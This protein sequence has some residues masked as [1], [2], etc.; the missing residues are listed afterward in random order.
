MEP[1]FKT[2]DNGMR[3]VFK[4]VEKDRP[5]TLFVCVKAGSVN[6]TD[7]N[8]GISHFIEHLNFKGT[9]K[10]SAKQIST[11]FEEIGANANAF[12]SKFTTCYFATTLAEQ[13][14][15]CFDILSDIIF[16]SKYSDED[17]DRE[18]K[19]VFE[20][21]DM[22][23]DDPESVSYEEFTKNFYE[24]TTLQ[25][26]VLGTK[27]SLKG[28]TRQDIVDYVKSNYIAPNIIVSVVGH[29]EEDFIEKLTCKYFSNRFKD[30]CALPQIDK[31]KQVSPIKKF[32][33]IEKDVAQTHITFGFPCPNTY[34]KNRMAYILA[35][36]IFGGG[37]GSRLFQKVREEKGL[38]YSITSMPEMSSCGGDFVINLGTNK[39]NS[40]RA[41]KII[42]SEI[43]N[44][45]EKGFKE[46]ELA[47]AKIFSKSLI[48]SSSELGSDIAK[49]N[50]LSVCTYGKIVSVKDKLEKID[51][52]TLKDINE[53]AQNVFDYK[54]VCGCVV[55]SQ[56]DKTLFEIFD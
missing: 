23:A 35:G 45:K 3:L 11:E 52:V 5:A 13:M 53:V 42:K 2:F 4:K 37:M 17:I 28:I 6:E 21:I 49:S 51:N 33:F 30:S 14:E 38:V 47:R 44:L 54:R 29:F 55:S 8:N 43:D 20:E 50:A 18:R 1:F 10:R 24:G 15:N 41:I 46:E 27:K 16:N 19:V 12:T 31:N 36:F 48:V 32:S 56:V 39:K 34:A 7:K 22:Y 40:L 25:K 26:T 9:Q